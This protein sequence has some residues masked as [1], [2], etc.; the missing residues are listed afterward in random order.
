MLWELIY[1]ALNIINYFQLWRWEVNVRPTAETLELG[2]R[3]M[4][5]TLQSKLD[6]NSR[7]LLGP[8]SIQLNRPIFA[9]FW[10][11]ANNNFN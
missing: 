2:S 1:Y 3:E 9:N 8:F 5:I 10:S 4:Y 11:W 6:E 7:N